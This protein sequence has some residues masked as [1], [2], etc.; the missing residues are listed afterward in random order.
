MM[1]LGGSSFRAWG[2]CLLLGSCVWADSDYLHSLA[3]AVGVTAP[4]LDLLRQDLSLSLL[5]GIFGSLG[6]VLFTDAQ[7]IFGRIFYL[8]NMGC[9]SLAALSLG[10]STTVMVIESAGQGMVMGKKLQQSYFYLLFRQVAS[11][12]FMLPHFNGY[13][14]IQWILMWMVVQGVYLADVVWLK[15]AEYLMTAQSAA[16]HV[17]DVAASDSTLARA[18]H[19]STEMERG[20]ATYE[21]IMSA[22]RFLVSAYQAVW[23]ATLDPLTRG[24]SIRALS[25]SDVSVNPTWDTQKTWTGYQWVFPGN[26]GSMTIRYQGMPQGLDAATQAVL[27]HKVHDAIR[28]SLQ[29]LFDAVSSQLGMLQSNGCLAALTA[30]MNAPA[31]PESCEAMCDPAS[32]TCPMALLMAQL[33]M[34]L[35]D[36]IN[37]ESKFF[38]GFKKE[39]QSPMNTLSRLYGMG[40]VGIGAQYYQGTHRL[41]GAAPSEAPGYSI[42]D[43][44]TWST[45][46]YSAVVSGFANALTRVLDWMMKP[47]DQKRAESINCREV[48]EHSESFLIW[49]CQA[50]SVSEQAQGLMVDLWSSI[51]VSSPGFDEKASWSELHEHYLSDLNRHTMKTASWTDISPAFW[52]LMNSF[53][54]T[55]SN[56]WIRTFL[57]PNYLK[58]MVA[59]PLYTFA[60]LAKF[61]TSASIS[62]MMKATG[63][64]AKDLFLFAEEV[65]GV[66]TGLAI[67]AVVVD[68]ILNSF[69]GFSYLETN[70]CW[71]IPG[72]MTYPIPAFCFIIW[73]L[74]F[75]LM[76]NVFIGVI[77]GAISTTARVMV[78]MVFDVTFSVIDMLTQIGLATKMNYISTI[79]AVSTPVLAL[80][81]YL[82]VYIPMLP[83]LMYT[84]AVVGWLSAVVEAM[85]G[86]PL[87]LLGMTSMQGHDLLGSAQQ[88]MILSLSVFLRPVTLVIGFMFG[89]IMLS[90]FG[91]VMAMFVVPYLG[92][93]LNILENMNVG[94]M[95]RGVI[96]AMIMLMYLSVYAT[97]IQLAFGAMFKI[98]FS[99]LRWIGLSGAP[100]Y[101]EEVIEQIQS[102]A[103]SQL[104]AM[105]GAFSG[106]SSGLHKA[107]SG[108]ESGKTSARELES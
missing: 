19:Y 5:S 45:A 14:G 59:D 48:N 10:Y 8:F 94:S 9:M 25:W 73:I 34:G 39:D 105:S 36:A 62:Y 29:P 54:V 97:V 22:E 53:S 64:V 70:A 50:Q 41:M 33:S 77:V 1:R 57:N 15:A 63:E 3:D 44:T 20:Q 38:S 12:A 88:A 30:N 75:P 47:T 56:V 104:G 27:L 106:M 76:I 68:S 35:A 6:D 21:Q 98:P 16:A 26:C 82:A 42:S 92:S 43:Y 11:V 81:S 83:V 89:V 80:A 55:A 71:S 60:Q 67:S 91:F 100:G 93:Y 79:F 107:G 99:I 28:F 2:L 78:K 49:Y 18:L 46:P 17:L 65:M 66:T 108:V 69:Q 74:F 31:L 24:Q 87:V 51:G 32:G 23:C 40:W 86:V 4:E 61:L 101:E 52:P 96:L 103:R 84:V 58:P 90:V 37:L 13:N 95:S 102:E 7:S 72:Q 85:I